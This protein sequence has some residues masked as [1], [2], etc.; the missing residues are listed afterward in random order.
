MKYLT[1]ND[2]ERDEK[3]V[4]VCN[5][6]FISIG[7]GLVGTLLFLTLDSLWFETDLYGSSLYAIVSFFLSA[8][9]SAAAFRHIR[10]SKN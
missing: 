4:F 8:I 7:G 9:V 1:E 3:F 6:I 10:L 2:K 5:M